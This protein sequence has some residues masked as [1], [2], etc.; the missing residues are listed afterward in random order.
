MFLHNIITLSQSI[1]ARETRSMEHPAEH[2]T[3]RTAAA[4]T[5]Y[6]DENLNDVERKNFENGK[7]TI[8]VRQM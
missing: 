6:L 2:G 1:A 4:V 8:L 5:K 7:K 3:N